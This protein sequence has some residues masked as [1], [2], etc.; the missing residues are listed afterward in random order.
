VIEALPFEIQP[1]AAETTIAV[2]TAEVPEVI[3]IS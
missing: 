1:E 3:S 2:I